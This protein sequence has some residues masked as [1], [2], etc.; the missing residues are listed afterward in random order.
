MLWL[1]T[2]LI[3]PALSAAN[4]PLLMPGKQAL[5]QRMLVVPLSLIHI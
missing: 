4:T 3:A 2:L 5:Y 1:A